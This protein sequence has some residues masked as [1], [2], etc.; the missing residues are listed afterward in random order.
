MKLRSSNV[1]LSSAKADV[2][3][4]NRLRLRRGL[5]FVLVA[6]CALVLLAGAGAGGDYYQCYQSGSCT[7]HTLSND[8]NCLAGTDYDVTVSNKNSPVTVLSF[9]GGNIEFNTS[10]ISNT[11]STLYAWSRYDFN[12]HPTSACTAVG[13]GTYQGNKLHITAT[14]F[15]DVRAVSLVSAQPKAV[16]IHGY[17]DSRGYAKGVMCVGGKDA[18]ARSAFISYVNNNAATWNANSNTT[19]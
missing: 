17:D 15:N 1:R 9:H 4:V 5:P 3:S 19:L 13:A 10:G 6:F 16:A 14:N 18:A 11:L 12:A 8:S 2:A 7:G